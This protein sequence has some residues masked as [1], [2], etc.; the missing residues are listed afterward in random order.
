MQTKIDSISDKFYTMIEN[1]QK[2]AETRPAF[3]RKQM[4]EVIDLMMI[5]RKED[6]ETIVNDFSTILKEKV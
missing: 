3:V 6:I 5:K 1:M 2:D 4:L